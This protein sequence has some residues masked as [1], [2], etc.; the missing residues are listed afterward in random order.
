MK[1]EKLIKYLNE[2]A[3]TANP[4]QLTDEEVDTILASEPELESDRDENAWP[5]FVETVLSG[6]HPEIIQ[7]KGNKAT[8]GDFLKEARRLTNFSQEC[9]AAAIGKDV[10]FI[11]QVEASNMPLSSFDAGDTADLISLL[12]IHS[13]VLEQMLPKQLQM[14]SKRSSGGAGLLALSTPP[15]MKLNAHDAKWLKAVRRALRT[16]E[17]GDLVN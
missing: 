7:S 10:N 16:R 2:L 11:Q 13:N 6:L 14:P 9:V 3:D 15:L 4:R 17:H 12:R 1:D 5:K 8:L